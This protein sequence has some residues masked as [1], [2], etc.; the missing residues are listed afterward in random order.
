MPPLPDNELGFWEPETVVE[1]HY[2]YFARIG[3]SWDDVLPLP[4]NAF[5]SAPAIELRE[6]LSHLL[7]EEYAASS[8]F[9]V[10]DPRI[11]RLLPLWYAV[12]EDIRVAAATVIAVRNPLEVAA[13]LE[14]RDGFTTTKSLLIWL[15]H[16]LEAE[17]HSRG[18]PRSIVMYDELLRDWQGVL[19]RVGDDLGLVWP[20]LPDQAAAEVEG[21]L[22][23]E[24]RHHVFD[25]D[26]LEG[27]ADVA[28]WVKEVYLSLRTDDPTP[29]LD[30]VWAELSQ[31]DV[32]FGPLLAQARLGLQTSE[33]QLRASVASR[34]GLAAELATKRDAL[35]ARTAEAQELQA[36]VEKLQPTVQELQ[37][38]VRAL[39]ATFVRRVRRR[40][41]SQID[42]WKSAA[43]YRS[44]R[45]PASSL[46]PRQEGDLP[47]PSELTAELRATLEG[48]FD[49]DHYLAV[50]PDVQAAGLDPLEHYVQS[51]WREGRDPSTEFSTSYYL[52][53]NPDVAAVEI[54]PFAHYVLAGRSE[55]RLPRMPGGLRREM[56]ENL[57]SVDEEIEHWR[58]TH[59]PVATPMDDDSLRRRL[60]EHIG[61]R[62]HVVISCSHDDYTRVAG[63]IQLCM[64]LEE[65]AFA[66]RGCAYLN[67]HPAQQLPV[68]SRETELA[69]MMLAVVCDGDTLGAASEDAILSALTHLG[70]EGV[71]FG[72]VVHAL[73]G[74]SPEAIAELYERLQPRWAWLWLHDFFVICPGA[75]LL[76]NNIERCHAPPPE[77]AGCMICVFGDERLRHLP[78]LRELLDRVPFKL[79]APSLFMA[80]RWKKYLGNESLEVT[81][82][83]H[84]AVTPKTTNEPGSDPVRA[85][86]DGSV[87]IAFIGHPE[88]HK[89]W[90]TFRELVRRYAPSGEYRFYHFVAVDYYL[91]LVEQRRVSVVEDG[92]L[93]MIDALRADSID[94]VVVWSIVE[95]S[96]G[97]TTREALAAGAAVVTNL[98]SG[99]VA[100]VVKAS[101]EGLVF[102]DERDLFAAFDTGAILEFVRSRRS[103]Q[104]PEPGHFTHSHVTAD[105]A[106]FDD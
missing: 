60:R 30:Q 33:E 100:S 57:R 36:T 19:S 98:G 84:G 95:E 22:S 99:N 88:L 71:D 15:R 81:V 31:A 6:Q 65:A 16:T 7:L 91:P 11:S 50:Y 35:E 62:R 67:L 53:A 106:N 90:E 74:H 32:V 77:S 66:E 41:R 17:L 29:L 86:V 8:L 82:H 104:Q 23:S 45:L 20:N 47:P 97:Y 105:L 49:P 103:T 14:A 4:E 63:G 64:K 70:S 39:Q 26:M 28:G 51:G 69:E 76:R 61:T 2:E 83:V 89:G 3:S 55:G 5:T 78:R 34:E 1:A 40:A 72:L 59:P 27:R 94:L 12:L 73:H 54:N 21:F 80:D 75:T 68:L 43:T 48:E 37:A 9:V 102:G 42:S 92:P 101:G 96:F 85:S 52:S 10:K 56:L 93:A 44:R 87:R 46:P 79:A 18:R 38:T 25:S 13:S 58:E 24:Q